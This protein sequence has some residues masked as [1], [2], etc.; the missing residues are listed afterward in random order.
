MHR[1]KVVGAILA[2]LLTG[3]ISLSAQQGVAV[4]QVHARQSLV[5]TVNVPVLDAPPSGGVLYVKGQQT[6][7][8]RAGET[9]TVNNEQTVSTVLGKQKWIYISRAPSVAPASGWVLVG[10]AGGTSSSFAEKH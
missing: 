8:L 6:G 2:V 4:D 3:A 9:V 7:N 5:A 10:T 1:A